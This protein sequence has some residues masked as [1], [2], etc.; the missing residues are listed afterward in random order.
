MKSI[1]EPCAG[2]P[3]ARFDEGEQGKSSGCLWLGRLRHSSGNGEQMG[4][5]REAYRHWEQTE[6]VL[7]SAL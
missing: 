7:Y 6:P 1:G 3:H 4:W 5:P 2:E